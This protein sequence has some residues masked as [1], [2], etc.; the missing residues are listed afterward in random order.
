MPLGNNTQMI[1]NPPLPG[2]E[3][4]GATTPSNLPVDKPLESQA[5][6]M[7]TPDGP[8]YAPPPVIPE[9]STPAPK[10]TSTPAPKPTT[11]APSEGTF[12]NPFD[13]SS[14][15]SES[16]AKI[17]AEDYAAMQAM[18][19][20]Q[21]A[22]DDTATAPTTTT[23]ETK[24]EAD[25]TSTS[26]TEQ[27]VTPEAQAFEA[28]LTQYNK[29]LESD[30]T[31]ARNAFASIQATADTAQLAMINAINASWQVRLTDM[32]QVNEA[33]LK[34]Q[35]FA[36]YRANRAR[37]A[38]EMQTSILSNEERRGIQ[39]LT[40]I[41]ATFLTLLAEAQKAATGEDLT[42][43][44][45]KLN[46]IGKLEDRRFEVAKNIYNLSVNEE[47]R[48]WKRK[49]LELKSEADTQKMIFAQLDEFAKAGAGSFTDADISMYATKLNV[50]SDVMKGYIGVQA[51]LMEW[52]NLESKTEALGN[53]FE[54][55]QKAPSDMEFIFSINGEDVSYSGLDYGD[56]QVF[57]E[58]NKRTGA[59]SFITIDKNTGKIVG[60][61][62]IGDVGTPYS[63]TNG[64]S[65]RSNMTETDP[66]SGATRAI[67]FEEY[68]VMMD[69][70]YFMS[71]DR[72]NKPLMDRF[73]A[74]YE[75][76]LKKVGVSTDSP[77]VKAIM[78][79]LTSTQKSAML[80]SFLNANPGKTSSDYL[81]LSSDEQLRYRSMSQAQIREMREDDDEDDDTSSNSSGYRITE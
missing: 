81:S 80:S 19:E 33:S 51:S 2:A 16:N 38:P 65:Q 79:K 45:E 52:D 1:P 56:N 78:K 61:E 58:V 15:V 70:K 17:L 29:S 41:D 35:T 7:S 8:V 73:R 28:Q 42:I 20:A 53:M 14:K 59:M 25:G 46:Q 43:L 67:T 11:P 68:V 71:H 27:A 54:M 32:K 74:E 47:E 48:T 50:S 37:Y 12:D 13:G 6:N 18:K 22:K 26:K 55:L 69:D 3:S 72:S 24:I 40:K 77:E 63:A 23:T 34:A 76:S 36:G 66:I 31:S 30:I 10:P 21:E 39:E 62:T 4:S 64:N 5:P 60:Q 75:G 9:A 44:S 57:K 49:E